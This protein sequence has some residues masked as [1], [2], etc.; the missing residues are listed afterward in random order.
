M[1][2]NQLWHRL[3][4]DATTTGLTNLQSAMGADPT[5]YF[6]S[7]ATSV[8]TDDA[9]PGID[10]LYT[11]PSWNWPQVY[12][13]VGNVAYPAPLSHVLTSGSAATATLDAESVG[14]F[15]FAVSNGQKGLIS[16]TAPG[17]AAIPATVRLTLVRTK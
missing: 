2:N 13:R 7:W 10:P 17:G 8:F 15:R 16:V 14:F 5:T 12:A 11:Q 3:V 1:S 6:R 9:V 4:R